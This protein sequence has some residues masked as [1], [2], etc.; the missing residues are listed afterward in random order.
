MF[1]WFCLASFTTYRN[2]KEK[3]GFYRKFIIF[4]GIWLFFIPLMLIVSINVDSS[5]RAK[6]AQCWTLL[7]GSLAHIVFLALYNPA[8][9]CNK[10][11]PFHANTSEMLS[12]KGP[13]AA[14]RKG[15]SGVEL[16][17][18]NALHSQPTNPGSL[19]R[20]ETGLVAGSSAENLNPN[21]MHA[22]DTSETSRLLNPDEVFWTI[23]SSGYQLVK[24]LS[25]FRGVAMDLD[26]TLRDWEG[27]DDGDV[28][29]SR[30]N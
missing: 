18:S 1:G 5:I 10:S 26:S 4:F 29:F 22:M 14:G 15:Q 12:T 23:R 16:M 19:D 9:R 30:Q 17:K 25:T 7:L 28:D 21:P 3:R 20:G 6:F 11:F 8:T 13:P 24:G 2:Y 27:E